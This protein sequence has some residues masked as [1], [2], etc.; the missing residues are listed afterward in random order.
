MGVESFFRTGKNHVSTEVVRSSYM[1]CS[2]RVW[3]FGCVNA[4]T[5]AGFFLSTC[6]R[7]GF[8]YGVAGRLNMS[9]FVEVLLQ[10]E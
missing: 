6:M 9:E 1:S 10:D 8:V 5:S 3:Q 7:R 4:P 2:Q